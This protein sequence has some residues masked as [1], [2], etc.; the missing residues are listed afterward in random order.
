MKNLI[1]SCYSF[2]LDSLNLFSQYFNVT[3]ESYSDF[4]TNGFNN[5]THLKELFDKAIQVGKAVSGIALAAY[6]GYSGY[7]LI[8]LF[9]EKRRNKL[10][11]ENAFK[12]LSKK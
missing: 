2:G 8:I 1:M 12:N 3:F 5:F 10:K 9:F 6:N 11:I 4:K 7:K